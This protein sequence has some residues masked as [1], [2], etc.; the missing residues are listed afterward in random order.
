MEGLNAFMKILQRVLGLILLLPAL[1]WAFFFIIGLWLPNEVIDEMWVNAVFLTG[2][3]PGN[4][5]S[6][7]LPLYL[8]TMA[9]VGAYLIKE[10]NADGR[11]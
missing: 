8:G 11:R 10:P 5:V 7:N 3:Y 6:V 9:A 2:G 4:E 1:F